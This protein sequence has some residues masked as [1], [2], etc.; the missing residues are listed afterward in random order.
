MKNPI[1]KELYDIDVPISDI[2]SELMASG[3]VVEAHKRHEIGGQKPSI[4]LLASR[5]SYQAQLIETLEALKKLSDIRR[6][7]YDAE[8]GNEAT[9]TQTSKQFSRGF[10][11]II[12]GEA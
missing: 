9:V 4:A 3:E 8:A 10:R 2:I 12:R 11:Q 5:A 6:N 7:A 1:K